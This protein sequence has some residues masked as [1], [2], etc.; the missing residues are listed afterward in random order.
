MAIDLDLAEVEIATAVAQSMGDTYAA[1]DP[2]DYVEFAEALAT[3]LLSILVHIT[4][5]A[6]AGGDPV[7]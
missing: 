4:D 6:T 1:G 2:T 3:G 5:N 7:E